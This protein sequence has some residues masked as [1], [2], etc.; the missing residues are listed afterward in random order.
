[1]LVLVDKASFSKEFRSE[2]AVEGVMDVA[3]LFL[4]FMLKVVECWFR[5]VVVQ[6]VVN[7][8]STDCCEY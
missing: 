3:W 2:F 6:V 7:I 5:L 1:M 4:F 8:T